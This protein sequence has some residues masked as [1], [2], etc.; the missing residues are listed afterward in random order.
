MPQPKPSLA[1]IEEFAR[2][3]GLVNLAAEHIARMA[4]LAVYVGELGRTLPRP[5]RKEDAPAAP[6]LPGQQVPRRQY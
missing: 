6:L 1:E 5:S 4:E 3:H 2:L